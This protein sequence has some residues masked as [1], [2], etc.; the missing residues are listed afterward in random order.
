M[1]RYTLEPATA[2]VPPSVVFEPAVPGR[3]R[4]VRVDGRPAQLD[5]RQDGDRT[6]VPLQ[7]PVD[8]P[9]TVEIVTD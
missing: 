6:I 1:Y 2:A 3:V 7:I 5:T 4:E 8:A 9:R